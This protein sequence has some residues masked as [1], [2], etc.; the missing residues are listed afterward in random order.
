MQTDY[1][2]YAGHIPV[3]R[4]DSKLKRVFFQR[5]YIAWLKLPR[6]SELPADQMSFHVYI[7]QIENYNQSGKKYSVFSQVF[8]TFANN[9]C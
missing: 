2:E 8:V 9:V 7:N 6:F 1:F 4:I 5:K 3:K